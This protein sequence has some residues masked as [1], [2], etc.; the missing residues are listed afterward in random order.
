MAETTT[1]RERA[2]PAALVDE[3][4][5]EFGVKLD[6]LSLV[7]GYLL[8]R[9]WD[10]LG[11]DP[12][13]IREW[14]TRYFENTGRK[15]KRRRPGR[16]VASDVGEQPDRQARPSSSQDRVPGDDGGGG[17]R[18]RARSTRGG[19]LAGGTRAAAGGDRKAAARGVH[20]PL[21]A[22]VAV[23]TDGDPVE[24]PAPTP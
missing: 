21:S 4:A 15:R 3:V 6:G 24:T 10:V 16:V 14:M 23:G 9:Q 19:G 12:D 20:P 2:N 13:K 22:E 5:A 11:R 7:V 8:G 18:V 17:G 1:E